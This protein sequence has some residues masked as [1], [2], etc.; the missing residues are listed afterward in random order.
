MK[1]EKFDKMLQKMLEGKSPE[2]REE[3]LK[4]ELAD[5]RNQYEIERTNRKW[6]TSLSIFLF[7]LFLIFLFFCKCER[8]K[9]AKRINELEKANQELL[10]ENV[11]LECENEHMKKEI[12]LM[13][14][15][16]ELQKKVINNY[17]S[18][19]PVLII[20]RETQKGKKGTKVQIAE[21]D[22]MFSGVQE[23]F[24]P[25]KYVKVK[26]EKPHKT[27][28]FEKKVS[29]NVVIEDDCKEYINAYTKP[30]QDSLNQIKND[31]IEVVMDKKSPDGNFFISSRKMSYGQ[32]LSMNV[33][34]V[35]GISHTLTE[36]WENPY[37][38]KAEKSFRNGVILGVAGAGVYGVTEAMGHAIF[39]DPPADNSAAER[40]SATIK[41]LRVGA[42]VLG[43]ASLVEFGRA[44]H[45]HKLEGKYIVSP[46]TVGVS[47]NLSSL[48]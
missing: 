40:K 26:S 20:T 27:K 23:A 16:I 18:K 13:E 9:S 42:G 22:T 47:V 35:M 14:D 45:F 21:V 48:K 4:W 43:A 32:M 12:D 6:W 28:T 36:Y 15:V 11:R 8:D 19:K 44:W 25:D 7:V 34:P 29:E 46:T 3:I 17:E 38:R 31:S 10:I 33:N 39:Y 24:I 1:T 5:T 37:R 41:G 30:I 2:E